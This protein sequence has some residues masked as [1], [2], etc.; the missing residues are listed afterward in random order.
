MGRLVRANP[1]LKQTKIRTFVISHLN[2]KTSL[3]NIWVTRNIVFLVC[4][5]HILFESPSFYIWLN[6][7]FTIDYRTHKLE[8]Q[9][10]TG[11]LINLSFIDVMQSYDHRW[12]NNL[13]HFMILYVI[14]MTLCQ[15]IFNYTLHYL[16]APAFLFLNVSI[17][18][19]EI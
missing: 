9:I 10:Q 16:V 13:L 12:S 19:F 6:Q 5:R 8:T 1:A 11:L 3:T 2:K 7:L 17:G 18:M 15:K 14:L 4:L